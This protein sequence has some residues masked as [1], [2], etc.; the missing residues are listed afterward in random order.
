[1]PLNPNQPTKLLYRLLQ[2][3]FSVENKPLYIQSA[4]PMMLVIPN[5]LMYYHSEMLI[6][7]LWTVN[8]HRHCK[9]QC[10]FGSAFTTSIDDT[11]LRRHVNS[12]R[13]AIGK[14]KTFI[15][16]VL[17]VMCAGS[18]VLPANV[19]SRSASS[20]S[21]RRLHTRQALW[22]S[23]FQSAAGVTPSGRDGGQC[24]DV[25][26]TVHGLSHRQHPG[27]WGGWVSTRGCISPQLW[28][29]FPEYH[30]VSLVLLLVLSVQVGGGGE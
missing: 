10:H 12:T 13:S 1:M 18:V 29:W 3:S 20:S 27:W 21:C 26:D 25:A 2:L 19:V 30:R 22:P 5:N 7:F 24:S 9:Q 23:L 6:L 11:E 16:T 28:C 14:W 15:E 17:S 8:T 4:I